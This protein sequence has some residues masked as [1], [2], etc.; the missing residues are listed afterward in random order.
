MVSFVDQYNGSL[1]IA[2]LL[3]DGTQRQSVTLPS[4]DWTGQTGVMGDHCRLDQ[5][6]YKDVSAVWPVWTSFR[7]QKSFNDNAYF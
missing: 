6:R 3:V 1:T 2:E 4:L 7:Y 5:S